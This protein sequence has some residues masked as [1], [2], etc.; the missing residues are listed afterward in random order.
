MVARQMLLSRRCDSVY[1][2]AEIEFAPKPVD[3]PLPNS[4]WTQTLRDHHELEPRPSHDNPTWTDQD[5]EEL[6]RIEHFRFQATKLVVS[7]SAFEEQTDRQGRVYDMLPRDL[8]TTDKL[9]FFEG[10]DWQ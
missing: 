4:G 3:I 6:S 2:G 9:L 5:R 10:F 1:F 7:F 8:S